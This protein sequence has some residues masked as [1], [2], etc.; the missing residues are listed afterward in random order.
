MFFDIGWPELML[1]GVIALVVIGPKDLPRA[2]RTAGF[3]VRKARNMS[4]EFQ[5]GID[6]MIREAELDDLRNDLKKAS[7]FDFDHEFHRTV[8]PDGTLTESIKPAELPD[9]FVENKELAQPVEG[10]VAAE[11]A[12][13]PAAAMPDAAPSAQAAAEAS[14]HATANHDTAAHVSPADAPAT[15]AYETG[16]HLPQAVPPAPQPVPAKP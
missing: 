6:Q 11:A 9:Y 15:H 3:W 4:R 8:D 5:N 1:I 13:L 14:V 16:E 7:E 2:L 10:A 12:A